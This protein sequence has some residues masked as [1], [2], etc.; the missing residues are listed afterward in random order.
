MFIATDRQNPN[1]DVK[2]DFFDADFNHLP[3]KQGH[4]NAKV[5]PTKPSSF[6]E[7]KIIAKKLSKGI[8]H[9]RIDLYEVNGRPMFG[10]MTFYHFAG[11]VTFKPEEW[12]YKFGEWLS[13]P[14]V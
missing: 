12:D 7:M 2:F 14:K 8:P 4:E 6:E 9:V 10:E 3:F 13:L 1:E 11:M 5:L